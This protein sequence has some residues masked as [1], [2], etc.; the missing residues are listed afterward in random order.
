MVMESSMEV[1]RASLNRGKLQKLQLSP[2]SEQGTGE[3]VGARAIPFS[4]RRDATPMASN[5]K[6]ARHNGQ[7]HYPRL[8]IAQ[9]MAVTTSAYLLQESGLT[10]RHLLHSCGLLA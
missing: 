5:D 2:T 3:N 1:A 9:C 6:K 8:Q 7:L 4:R 10:K